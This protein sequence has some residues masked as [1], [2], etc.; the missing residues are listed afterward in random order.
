MTVYF[1][2][3]NRRDINHCVLYPTVKEVKA[4]NPITRLLDKL[5]GNVR[6][7]LELYSSI[8]LTEGSYI[9]YV[10]G[11]D[12]IAER[13][14][15]VKITKILADTPKTFFYKLEVVVS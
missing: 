15:T 6:K 4:K 1:N 3:E 11:Q 8:K 12:E 7:Q 14:E 5:S 2:K 13:Y 10:V 9:A